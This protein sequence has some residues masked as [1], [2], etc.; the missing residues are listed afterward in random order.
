MAE[1]GQRKV[2]ALLRQAHPQSEGDSQFDQNDYCHDCFG[3]HLKVQVESCQYILR[4]E[5][6][7]HFDR[8]DYCQ[9][10]IG[11]DLFITGVVLR[12]DAAKW[13]RCGYCS[14]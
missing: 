9:I 14:E 6:D 7:F 5:E 12:D 2:H 11:A 4:G 8:G 13:Q 10:S 3:F 1:E